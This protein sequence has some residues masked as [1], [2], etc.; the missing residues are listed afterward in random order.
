MQK[1]ESLLLECE[2]TYKM[3]VIFYNFVYHKQDRIR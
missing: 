1:H 2:L 3:K